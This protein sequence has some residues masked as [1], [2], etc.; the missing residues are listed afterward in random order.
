[1]SLNE[2]G[3]LRLHLLED[4]QEF[5]ALVSFGKGPS[6]TAVRVGEKIADESGF[7]AE[8]GRSYHVAFSNADNRLR[9]L[10]DGALLIEHNYDGDLKDVAEATSYAGAALSVV[11]AEAEFS[12][13]RL[14]R[15]VSYRHEFP[16]MRYV[17]RSFDVPEDSYFV[18]GDN[19]R[20][21]RD[22]RYWGRV[23]ESNLIGR[24]VV[25]WW[26]LGHLRAIH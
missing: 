12:H 8:P 14:D 3:A 18:C 7:T 24:A 1:V 23:P 22:S 9:L 26:P 13:V 25:V 16:D 15:D 20:N 6:A 21:S 4:D 17:S 11:G 2:P 10:V 19:S 5:T